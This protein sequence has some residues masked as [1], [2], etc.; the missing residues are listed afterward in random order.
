M[1]PPPAPLST[2]P[3]RARRQLAARLARRKE[4]KDTS[5]ANDDDNERQGPD[6]DEYGVQFPTDKNH[7]PVSSFPE[8]QGEFASPNSSDE[9]QPGSTS[10]MP[11]HSPRYFEMDDFDGDDIGDMVSPT[12]AGFPSPYG[13]V[14]DDD[15]DDDDGIIR[16]SLGYSNFHEYSQYTGAPKYPTRMEKL[17]VESEERGN[18][19][20]ED[21]DEKL[22][23]ISVPGKK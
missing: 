21:E 2:G 12:S 1:I 6:N 3:S 9:E 17:L 10:N 16:E 20:D 13:N 5:N 7:R 23:E 19:S 4:A 15:D 18:S 11:R 8:S 14:D 22:V